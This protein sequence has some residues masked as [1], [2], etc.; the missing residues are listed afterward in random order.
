MA[1]IVFLVPTH[2]Q[3]SRNYRKDN[4]NGRKHSDWRIDY[5]SMDDNGNDD[6]YIYI[7][8]ICTNVMPIKITDAAKFNAVF[9]R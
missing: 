8:H 1:Q 4:G 5:V 2:K 9:N 3:Y 6:G 7:M